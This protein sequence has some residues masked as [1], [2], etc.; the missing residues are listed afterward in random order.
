MYLG[1]D[2]TPLTIL[3]LQRTLKALG[4]IGGVG[5]RLIQWHDKKKQIS[6]ATSNIGGNFISQRVRQ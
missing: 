5:N 2:I 3:L 6:K 1:R 4:G